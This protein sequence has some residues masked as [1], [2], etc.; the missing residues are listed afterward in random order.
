MALVFGAFKRSN[1]VDNE[2]AQPVLPHHINISWERDPSHTQTV[3]WRT[4]SARPESYL[5]YCKA[6]A[7]PFFHDKIRS[8]KASTV[9]NRA[10]DG[11]WHY[12]SVHLQDLEAN[13]LYSYRVGME[14]SWSEWSE[15][16]TAEGRSDP[17]S[18]LYFGDVQRDIHSLGSR[19][20]R[21][22]ILDKPDA[23]FLFF[24]GDMVH[25]GAL[26][27]QNW[28]DFFKAGGWIFQNYPIL[29]TPGNHEHDNARSGIDLSDNWYLNFSFP[30]NGP[31]GHQEE[32]YYLDYNNLRIISLNLC[33]F[34]YEEERYKML[35]WLEDRLQEFEGDWIIVVHHYPM[36]LCKARKDKPI[37]RF[38]EF[39]AMYE[40]YNVP[41]VLTGHAHLYA[42]G[43]IGGE[44][45]VYV[46]SVAGPHQN[47]IYFDDWVER[48]GTSLQLF[49]EIDI[50]PDTMH[51]VS[52]T[53][54]GEVYDEFFIIK[55]KEREMRFI[56]YDGLG[57]ESL[58]P[59]ADFETRYDDEIVK[60]FESDRD[61]YLKKKQSE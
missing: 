38:P 25:R 45:P 1:E 24:G 47:A 33:K 8:V 60:S 30:T 59:P 10:D 53:H 13:S 17:F 31:E 7:S 40:R 52:K 11:S 48:A 50:T 2:T 27:R 21:Q 12:H 55:D 57:P 51:Y 28:N 49:Q 6:T 16:R 29:A 22:A 43:R 4:D 9:A 14:E 44:L 58:I 54:L 5:E 35:H 20:I 34:R 61:R 39:K 15:F 3:T 32:T 37:I 36:I 18:F 56:Q 19:I 26:N 23:R 42:R 46:I 41:L